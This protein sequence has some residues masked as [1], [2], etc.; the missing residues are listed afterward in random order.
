VLAVQNAAHS[1]SAQSAVLTQVHQLLIANASH[2]VSSGEVVLILGVGG[3]IFR[4]D[5]ASATFKYGGTLRR[6]DG[7]AFVTGG[8]L[9]RWDETDELFYPSP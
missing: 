3:V 1:Q 5:R 8:T 7:S 4:W 6:W 2:A 9:R